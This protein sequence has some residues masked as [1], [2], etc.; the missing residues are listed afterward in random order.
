MLTHTTLP[1]LFPSLLLPRLRFQGLVVAGSFGL[2]EFMSLRVS[3]RDEKARAV[4]HPLASI[5]S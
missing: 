4:R 3:L 5:S 1:Q 2:R